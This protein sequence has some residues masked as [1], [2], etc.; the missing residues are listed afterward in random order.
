MEESATYRYVINKGRDEGRAEGI[1]KG[2]AEGRTEGKAEEIKRQ[3][4]MILQLLAARLGKLPV[5][6]EQRL[7][8]MEGDELEALFVRLLGVHNKNDLRRLLQELPA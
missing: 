7:C 2:K 8:R 4:R 3:Q 5:G 6:L 1:A